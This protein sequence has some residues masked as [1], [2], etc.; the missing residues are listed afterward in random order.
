MADWHEDLTAA[1]DGIVD[2]IDRLEACPAAAAA[3]DLPRLRRMIEKLAV[4]RLGTTRGRNALSLYVAARHR[5]WALPA[6]RDRK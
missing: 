1:R 4:R 5:G 6:A 2:E 3:L